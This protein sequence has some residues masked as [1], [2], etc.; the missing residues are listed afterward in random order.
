MNRT[1]D[2]IKK[3]FAV[4]LIFGLIAGIFAYT[5]HLQ[6]TTVTDNEQQSQLAALT[7]PGPTVQS[8][9]GGRR[10]ASIQDQTEISL[11]ESIEIPIEADLIRDEISRDFYR[12]NIHDKEFYSQILDQLNKN[13]SSQSEAEYDTVS[14]VLSQNIILFDHVLGFEHPYR[15]SYLSA[16]EKMLQEKEALANELS[17]NKLNTDEFKDRMHSTMDKY[18]SECADFLTEDD[19]TKLFLTSKNDKLSAHIGF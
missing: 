18:Q 6:R 4:V 19:F 5:N 7:I 2:L 13:A 11:I 14:F 9:N 3:L 12:Q 8:I 16:T 1:K 10:P 15:L 17:A